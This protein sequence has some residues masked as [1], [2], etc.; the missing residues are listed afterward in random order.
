MLAVVLELGEHVSERECDWVS[1]GVDVTDE[2]PVELAEELKLA[3][4]DFDTL[5]VGDG[6]GVAEPDWL[7]VD[8]ALSDWL[9]L[10]VAL[11]LPVG[12]WL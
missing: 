5:G 10:I 12:D 1:D 7:G 11:R 6:D 8:K 4:W 2:D 9:G 3:D